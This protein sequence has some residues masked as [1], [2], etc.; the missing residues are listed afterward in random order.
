VSEPRRPHAKEHW[1]F[2]SAA[3][4]AEAP[5][6]F[7]ADLS[8][9]QGGIAPFR[10]LHR[11][12]IAVSD[13]ECIQ[14]VLVTERE[15]YTR[16]FHLRNLGII[17]G[18]GLLATEGDFWWKRRRQ[19]Q[20][21]FKLDCMKRLVPAVCGVL[22]RSFD[23]WE[24][25]PTSEIAVLRDMQQL[26]MSAMGQMLMSAD[27][28]EDDVT[29]IGGALR[30]ALR[31]IRRRNTSWFAAP[32]WLPTTDNR[33]LAACRK[34]MDEFVGK[35]IARRLRQ[36]QPDLPDILNALIEAKDPETGEHLPQEALVDE[37]KTLFLAG[38]E[39]TAIALCWALYMIARH[40][41]VATNWRLELDRVLGDRAPTWDDLPRLEYT[42]QIVHETLRLYPPV[43]NMARESVA[44]DEVG[45]QRIAKGTIV[46]ISIYGMHRSRVWGEDPESFRPDRF[47]STCPWPKKAFLP[48]GSGKHICLGNH[49]ALTE[50]MVALAMLGQRYQFYPT[51]QGPVKETAQITLVPDRDIT[52]RISR[53]L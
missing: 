12:C 36:P 34:V 27:I 29:S 24:M 37:T 1:L 10:I 47:S 48:F 44:N 17:I 8:A 42:A 51:D 25:R 19:I 23:R 6:T 14:H 28:G 32:L 26:T 38:Y 39:T 11:R 40:P 46:V 49:F 30:Q 21:S 22:S 45:G 9:S 7:I 53:R 43:Y 31:L 13:P 20:P 18:T 3:A 41:E 15:R 4:L 5:H 2:G 16:S 35:H 52:L 33:D 50:M